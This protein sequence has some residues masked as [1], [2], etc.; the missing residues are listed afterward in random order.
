MYFYKP[1]VHYQLTKEQLSKTNIYFC[2]QSLIKMHPIFD[3]VINKILNKDKK[4]EVIFIKSRNKN[5]TKQFIDRLKKNINNNFDRIKFIERLE[6]EEYINKCGSAS[7]LLDTYW[8]GAGNSFHESMFYG[9]PT[10]TLPTKYLKSRIVTGA[11]KQMKIENAPIANDIEEYVEKS[12]EYANYNVN[13]AL[14]LKSHYKNQADK[15]LYENENIIS[16]ME[17]I[18]ES[19][20]NKN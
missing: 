3:T 1:K 17:N 12:V 15:Y 8:F 5:I 16:D 13:K 11:Y 7:V 19:I 9:T 20:I 4:A 18:F 2:G 6:T 10:I 14:E